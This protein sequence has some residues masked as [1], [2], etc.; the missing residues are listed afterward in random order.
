M[1]YEFSDDELYFIC[2][3]V[4]DKKD[5]LKKELAKLRSESDD[6]DD[7]DATLEIELTCLIGEANKIQS[8]INDMLAER[9]DN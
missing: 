9:S 6:P 4:S 3:A 5:E 2:D 1:N 7:I 8:V